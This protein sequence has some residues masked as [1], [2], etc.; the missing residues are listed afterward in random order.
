[1][2]QEDPGRRD[3][4]LPVVRCT[5]HDAFGQRVADHVAAYLRRHERPGRLAQGCGSPTLVVDVAASPVSVSVLGADEEEAQSAGAWKLSVLSGPHGLL[6]GPLRDAGRPCLSCLLQ[7]SDQHQWGLE[8][9]FTTD[10]RPSGVSGVSPLAARA[11]AA[12]VMRM[13][14]GTGRDDPP[15]GLAWHMEFPPH[16]ARALRVLPM[17]YCRRCTH[18]RDIS[19]RAVS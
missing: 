8:P 7:R 19:A 12:L 6:V 14:L 11:A 10:G 9:F 3:S 17:P 2:L 5:A 4:V 13:A 15:A 1:M 18:V 16:G